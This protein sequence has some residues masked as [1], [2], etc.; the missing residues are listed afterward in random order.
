MLQ[1]M[2]DYGDLLVRWNSR[3]N[4]TAIRG[5]EEI[6]ARHLV[7]CVAAAQA[8]PEGIRDL[9]DYGSG[10]G[11]PGIPIAVCRP[12]IAV[13]LCESQSKKAAFLREAARVLELKARVAAVRVTDLPRG[14][15]FDAI[16][17]RAVD[18]MKDAVR[19]A[20]VRLRREGSLVVF[21][22]ERVEKEIASV[23]DGM[24]VVRQPLPT[25]GELL[26]CKRI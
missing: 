12:E 1:Q 25:V 19:E 24:A 2:G 8:L 5:P 22:T 21:A 18:R 20:L 10:A 23:L 7:E 16:S 9:L 3:M 15:A 26:F 6:L 17:L 13:T 4:L 11:L 14:E